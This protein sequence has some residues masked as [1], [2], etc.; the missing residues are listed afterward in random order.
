MQKE[1]IVK[2]SCDLSALEQAC[3]ELNGLLLAKPSLSEHLI[4]PF[5]SLSQFIKLDVDGGFALGACDMRV[6]FKPSESFLNLIATL[7]ANDRHG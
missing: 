7:R 3:S 4:S 1:Y 2:P 6:L 5:E